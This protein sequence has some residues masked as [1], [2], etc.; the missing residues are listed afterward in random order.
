MPFLKQFAS[1][2]NWKRILTGSASPVS[3]LFFYM[4]I[5]A[6][7]FFMILLASDERFKGQVFGRIDFLDKLTYWLDPTLINLL[8]VVAVVVVATMS[9]RARVHK[10]LRSTSE[11][12]AFFTGQALLTASLVI[13]LLYLGAL[14]ETWL[15]ANFKPSLAPWTL[16]E[17]PLHRYL[18]G[19]LGQAEDRGIPSGAYLRQWWLTLAL[20]HFHEQLMIQSHIRRRPRVLRSIAVLVAC[21]VVFCIVAAVRAYRGWSTLFDVG[22]SIGIGTFTFWLVVLL[23]KSRLMG[24]KEYIT[25]LLGISFVFFTFFVLLS[26]DSWRWMLMALILYPVLAY[27]YATSS[28]P[29]RNYEKEEREFLKSLIRRSKDG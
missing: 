28:K 5:F 14:L 8:S 24:R 4:S 25:D 1:R 3:P 9:A 7:L 15:K 21:T 16:P 29:R 13:V 18:F 19:F 10:T 11:R 12:R 27:S 20:V 23:P 26:A 22:I 6:G 17:L 2:Q